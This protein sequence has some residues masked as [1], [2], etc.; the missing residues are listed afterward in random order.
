MG[1]KF[2]AIVY[3]RFVVLAACFSCLG[4]TSIF[5]FLSVRVVVLLLLLLLLLLF[6]FQVFFVAVL[7]RVVVLLCAVPFLPRSSSFR[8][9]GTPEGIT[10]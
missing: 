3:R 4:F 9:G 2:V 8:V 5:V 10:I 7:R 1:Y 6:A